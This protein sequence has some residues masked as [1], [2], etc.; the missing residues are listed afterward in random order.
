MVVTTPAAVTFTANGGVGGGNTTDGA[1]H[2]SRGGPGGTATTS[3]G[4]ALTLSGS[5]GGGPHSAVIAAADPNFGQTIG[6]AGIRGSSPQG[7][8]GG[9]PDYYDEWGQVGSAPGGGGS[10][11]L[12]RG[13]TDRVG[14]AGAMG[15]VVIYY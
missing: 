14:G 13:V 15:M 7:G 2:V 6:Y 3:A 9:Q 8:Y 4:T 12:H 5:T 1:T 10:G 11:G